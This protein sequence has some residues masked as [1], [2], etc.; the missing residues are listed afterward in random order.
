MK[1]FNKRSAAIVL[2]AAF[3][4]TGC[5]AN[6]D[7]T[8]PS[9]SDELEQT[10]ES[11]SG[12]EIDNTS[13]DEPEEKEE[14]SVG[15]IQFEKEY[16]AI[17]LDDEEKGIH[18][19]E[20]SYELLHVKDGGDEKSNGADLTNL[21]EALE[22]MNAEIESDA[23]ANAS[24]FKSDYSSDDSFYQDNDKT[25]AEYSH[26][27]NIEIERADDAA[28][29]ILLK[30]NDYMGGAHGDNAYVPYCFNTKS[31]QTLKWSDVM[32]DTTA[33]QEKVQNKAMSE[34]PEVFENNSTAKA[35]LQDAISQLV[36][37]PDANSS[38]WYLT[39]F[40]ITF[41]FGEYELGSYADGSQFVDLNYSDDTDMFNSDIT[42]NEIPD[43]SLLR[44]SSEGTT[45]VDGKNLEIASTYD[46]ESGT[47]SFSAVYDGNEI[48]LNADENAYMA[49]AYIAR[50]GEK[51][52]L[53]MEFHTDNDLPDIGIYD[54]ASGK[55]LPSKFEYS[56]SNGVNN[57]LNNLTVTRRLD[58]LSTVDASINASFTAD[59]LIVPNGSDYTILSNFG[60]PNADTPDAMAHTLTAKKDIRCIDGLIKEGETV[61][62]VK[63]NAD[64]KAQTITLQLSDD[65]TV[66][67][68]L[69]TKE[70]GTHTIDGVDEN[71]L[72]DGIQYSG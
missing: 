30:E 13:I 40:G 25:Y 57:D 64:E 6:G 26:M 19:G 16:K 15:V 5:S 41:I 43:G 32:K 67:V 31:G 47:N 52:F 70:D 46:E 68:L 18:Y 33:L 36:S 42:Y 1:I 45:P 28:V 9:G 11:G 56:L 39:P 2:T 22:E 61:K 63:T 3:L 59:G 37:D 69:E 66:T 38:R 29:S 71:E 35:A 60:G 62:L 50:K 72:F 48:P 34:Y 14:K 20:I 51:Y 44:I 53:L 27:V 49:D 21:S 54:L 58:A 10:T 24:Q 17:S 55:E 23:N 12:T 7:P 4:L 65:S 8:A